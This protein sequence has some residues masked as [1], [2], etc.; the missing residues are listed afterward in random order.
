[1]D[2][3]KKTNRTIAKFQVTIS[4]FTNEYVTNCK[5]QVQNISGPKNFCDKNWFKYGDTRYLRD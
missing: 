1:M 5:F 3:N 4:V 2:G